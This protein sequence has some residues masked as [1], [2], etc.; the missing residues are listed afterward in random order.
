[1]RKI[2]YGML[3]LVLLVS[4]LHLCSARAE[5]PRKLTLMV[6]M[7][8]SNLESGYGSA[9]ADLEEMLASGFDSEQVSLLVMTGGA[10][11]WVLGFDPA[12]LTINEIGRRGVRAVWREEAASMGVPETLTTLLNFGVERFPAEDYALI[13]WNHGGGPMEGVCRDELFSM[14][15][16]S[17][18]ELTQ[19]LEA[20]N[21]PGKLSW[22]GFDACLMSSAE[23]ASTLAPY[24]DYM[25]A[26]QETEP[27]PG[28]N[29]AFLKG[30]E[31][32]AS[33][34]DT[35]RRIVDAY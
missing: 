9:S 7:C 21:L 13:L 24:A 18:S 17:L 16:L 23:V 27:A 28:W 22:I 15:N 4:F 20:S 3:A 6:Y 12:N 14:D 35:G 33:A 11:G 10:E 19:A 31:S 8:G 26:S 34:A 32:D 1:M 25:I 5:A 29:Y 30:L 2:R